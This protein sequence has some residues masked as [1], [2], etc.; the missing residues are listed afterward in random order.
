MT[1]AFGV[2]ALTTILLVLL[3]YHF[4]SLDKENVS[5]LSYGMALTIAFTYGCSVGIL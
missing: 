2:N 5:S 1:L 3:P 4:Y